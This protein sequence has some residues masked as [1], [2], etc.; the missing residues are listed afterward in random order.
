MEDISKTPSR[1]QSIIRISETVFRLGFCLFLFALP[2]QTAFIFNEPHIGKAGSSMEGVWEYGKIAITFLDGMFVVLIV[3]SLFF[4]GTARR[5]YFSSIKRKILS[6]RISQC[7]ICLV[8]LSFLS[9]IWS[10]DRSIAIFA[11][12]RFLE[13]VGIF[14]II[15]FKG[16]HQIYSYIA[17]VVAAGLQ[18]I[19]ASWQF[20]TQEVTA[21]KWLGMAYHSSSQLGDVVIENSEVRWI[22]A[23]GSFPHPNILALFLALG[24]LAGFFLIGKAQRKVTWWALLFCNLCMTAGLFFTFSRS[25]WLSF[26]CAILIMGGATMCIR[27]KNTKTHR[28]L[29][30]S[31]KLHPAFLYVCVGVISFMALSLT[32]REPL[33]ARFGI[34][35]WSRLE[36]KSTSERM[37]FL[38]DSVS[39][40]RTHWMRGVGIGQYT[41]SVFHQ[42]E[43][44]GRS[45]FWYLYQPVHNL[46]FLVFTELGVIGFFLF[47]YIIFLFLKKI[48]NFI[49]LTKTN[50]IYATQFF[51]NGIFFL[52]ILGV[53]FVDHFLWTI[54]GGIFMFWLACG[55]L[56]RS[57]VDSCESHQ[58]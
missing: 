33:A 5:I 27:K 6:D 14:F 44:Q 42:D 58:T 53:G 2:W 24:I 21:N 11:A 52:T 31:H 51:I 19:L 30:S 45:R 50:G 29:P 37:Q 56:D 57:I 40:L 3:S 16:A 10:P 43:Q 49:Y 25:A 13:G 12:L 55:I 48:I 38:T 1:K 26:L 18:G 34:G 20:F 22:R 32:L 39:L 9:I 23:Y 7:F 41:N 36:Q 47:L 54:Q 8:F 46:Y 17:I 15:R 35:G 4:I 28:D